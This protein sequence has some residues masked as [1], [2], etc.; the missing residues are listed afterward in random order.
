MGNN[1]HA[2]S[3]LLQLGQKNRVKI[4]LLYTSRTAPLLLCL[5]CIHRTARASPY[6]EDVYK[7]QIWRLLGVSP[8][9]DRY[10]AAKVVDPI[11]KAEL[12]RL[13]SIVFE[14]DRIVLDWLRK[15]LSFA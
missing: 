5:M 8:Y 12:K 11:T 4:C 6:R 13:F 9:V 3:L 1:H 2:F 7:R 10:P 15:A 14:N